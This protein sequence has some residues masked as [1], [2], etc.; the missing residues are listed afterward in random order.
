MSDTKPNPQK[1]EVPQAPKM[2][3]PVSGQFDKTRAKL[4]SMVKNDNRKKGKK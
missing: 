1:N 2:V 4:K 3:K